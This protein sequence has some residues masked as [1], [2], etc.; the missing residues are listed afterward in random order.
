M[1]PSMP[2]LVVIVLFE[3]DIKEELSYAYLHA[4]ASRAGFGVERITKD[5]DSVDVEIR[6]RGKLCDGSI[7]KSTQVDVQLKCTSQ[8]AGDGDKYPFVLSRKNYDDLRGERSSPR[9]LVVLFL[10]QSSYS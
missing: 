9:I 1:A 5:R 6:A 4:I 8:D 7:L 2:S 10:P 3:N